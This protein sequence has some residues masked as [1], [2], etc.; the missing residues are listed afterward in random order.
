MALMPD[1]LAR[2]GGAGDQQMRHARK[3]GDHRHSADVLAQR[4]RQRRAH[5]VIRL[6]FDDLAQ[7]HDLALLVGYL[8]TDD[9]FAGN[10]F[11]DAN[12]DG[13]QRA[14]EILREIADLADLDAGRGPQFESRDHG[15]R[16]HRHD[17]GLHAEIAQ[18]ELDQARHRLQRFVRIGLLARPASSSKDNAGSSLDLGAS[19]SGT[20]R[21][22]STRSLFCGTGA[23]ASIRGGGRLA[24]FFC[25]SRTTSW[26]ACLR[27]WPEASSRRC[28]TRVRAQ[29]IAFRTPAPSWSMTSNQETPRNSATPASHNPRSSSVAP[30]KLKP[31]AL[32]RPASS[33]STPPALFGSEAPFQCSVARPQLV[34]K[35]QRESGGA[36]QGID[37]RASVGEPLLLVH[38]PARV[39]HHQREIDKPAG[40]TGTGKNPQARHPPDRSNY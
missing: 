40:R 16:L 31:C 12:A 15:T 2:P 38:Q 22:R 33:P 5:I 32:P 23:A 34:T 9:R 13:R 11:H 39:H 25:S 17:L 14:G 10:D 37:A 4:Q 20:C 36:Q 3:V 28:S 6:G 35:R 18:L 8:E 21:S 30:R 7:R 19:N 26:R 24:T 29:S 1:R 27:S